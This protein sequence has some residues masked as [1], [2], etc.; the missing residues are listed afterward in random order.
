MINSLTP[1]FPNEFLVIIII[2]CMI[3]TIIMTEFTS[4]KTLPVC[5]F[6]YGF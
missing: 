6:C 4:S 5:F 3:I 2:D 1:L